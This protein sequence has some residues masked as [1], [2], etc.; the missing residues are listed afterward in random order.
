MRAKRA[1]NTKEKRF[2]E[3]RAVMAIAMT[4]TVFL[5]LFTAFEVLTLKLEWNVPFV[6]AM[7]G[8]SDNYIFSHYREEEE[9]LELST[10]NESGTECVPGQEAAE[11]QNTSNENMANESVMTTEQIEVTETESVIAA[12]GETVATEAL[13]ET[14]S[15]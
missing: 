6:Y 12:D 4:A 1:G 13:E 7:V 11:E 3:G 8:G 14:E 2:Y 15:S 10:E 9:K 5:C